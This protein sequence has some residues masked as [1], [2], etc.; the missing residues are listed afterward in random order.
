MPI[1]KG[2]GQK[3]GLKIFSKVIRPGHAKILC[4][5]HLCRNIIPLKKLLLT[6]CLFISLLTTQAQFRTDRID[7]IRDSFGVPHIFA[8]TDPEV[9]YGLAWA[10]S[11]DDFFTIQESLI[12]GKA[13]SGIYKGKAGAQTDY[14]IHLMGIP[15]LVKAR[16]EKDLGEPF[17]RLL[18][19]YCAG[20]NAYA[21]AHSKEIL[22]KR[23][24]P[25]TPRDL[26]QYSVLQLCVL[27]GAD[28]ALNNIFRGT[29]PL[30]SNLQPGGSNAFAFNS[31]KTNNGHTFLTINAHQPLEG[32]VA[33][34]EAHLCSEEGWNILGANFPG[35]PCILHGANEYLG[36]AHTVNNPD[37]VDVY[38]LETDPQRS[39]QYK[40]DGQ[41]L[42]LEEKT[43]SLKVKLAG[44]VVPV[45]RKAYNSIYGP[46]LITEKGTFSV[47]MPA[48]TDVRG[49]EQWY[50]MNKARNYTEFRQVLEMM[51]IPGYNL[52][53]A[54]KYDTIFYISNGKIPIRK[55]GYNWRST[56]PGNTTATLWKEIHPLHELPQVLQPIGGYVYNTNHSPFNST[57][58]H[59]NPAIR[60][61]EMGYETLENNRSKRFAE[62]IQQYPKLS[63]E[64]MKRIKFDRS[65]PA[66]FAFPNNIDSLFLLHADYFPQLADLI[67]PLKEWN[68]TALAESRGAGIFLLVYKKAN[69]D[70]N[71]FLSSP[72]LTQT[73]AL[74][75]LLEV[76]KDMI[77]NYGRTDIT[78][79]DIQKLA[80]GDKELPVGGLPDVLATIGTV[81]Y[82][83]G[84]FK[85]NEGDAYVELVEFTPDGPIIESM[86]A[87]GASARKNSP[88]YTDQMERYT[89]QQTKRMSLDKKTVYRQ[90]VK[91]YHPQ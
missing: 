5:T 86:N 82:K 1:V 22:L 27:S 53:Y 19:G 59:D 62:L 35:A 83:N 21:K 89:R 73:Q 47:R 70:R 57:D 6:G 87:Y 66:Q 23:A 24:F 8:P 42:T 90:A 41:W 64:Q 78:L 11:E 9:A 52:V 17:K 63:F 28:K 12:I 25:V 33:F 75:L 65:Y 79:G 74:E 37:K 15:E 68:R 10:A 46:T 48:Q 20:L 58:G 80:R 71:R 43:V 88:H 3:A 40:V 13:L 16:Y 26:I 7:I 51:A 84:L 29:Q 67:T 76:R 72:R 61:P 45:K 32:P 36:W 18:E 4:L 30:L 39:L 2:F 31:K 56:V 54:D 91:L 85:G 34:Y 44:V 77:L 60:F 50:R 69:Q 38:Q 55:P 14:I 81:P 49:L